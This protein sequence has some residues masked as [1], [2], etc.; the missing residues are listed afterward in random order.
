MV[1]TRQ[2]RLLDEDEVRFLCLIVNQ[3]ALAIEKTRLHQEEIKRQR[4]E[5]EM[6][7]ARQIQLSLLPEA[8]PVLPGWEFATYYRPARQVGGDFYDFFELP[9]EAGELGMVIADVADK[10]VPAALLMALSRSI[11]RTKAMTPGFRPAEVL[12]RANRLIMKDSR[13]KLFLTA[14]YAALN[15]QTGCLIYTLAGHN[16]PLWLQ[17]STGKCQELMGRGA[18]LGIFEDL[19]LAEF[20]L[21]LAPGDLLVFYTDG[22]TEAM[23][24]HHQLFGEERLEAVITA[25]PAAT[26][27]EMLQAIVTAVYTFTNGAPQAD[28][29]TLFVVKRS[30]AE[31]PT[32]SLT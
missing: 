8:P 11:I 30:P 4:L 18:V 6:A 13:A 20:E 27:D 32:T 3:A 16:R 31:E 12:L 2:P 19:E 5:E 21:D 24:A 23:D 7:V 1:D 25:N 10:G 26:P 14:C 29:L 17:A 15:P 9:G 22:V 28:D